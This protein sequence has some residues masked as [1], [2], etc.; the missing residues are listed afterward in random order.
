MPHT[1]SGASP[2]SNSSRTKGAPTQG[3]QTRTSQTKVSQTAVSQ[4]AHPPV[5]RFR[6]PS[7]STGSSRGAS[8]TPSRV[9]APQALSHHEGEALGPLALTWAWLLV[10]PADLLIWGLLMNDDGRLQLSNQLMLF[11]AV[12]GGLL[13]FWGLARVPYQEGNLLL[14]LS[15]LGTLA[16]VVQLAFTFKG[17]SGHL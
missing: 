7:F 2:R 12:L 8:R 17:L 5:S 11:A 14:W 6:G 15:R 13:S 1:L 3:A 16:A 10:V 9:G 4:T